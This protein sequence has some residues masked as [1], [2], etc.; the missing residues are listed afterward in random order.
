MMLVKTRIGISKIQGIGIFADEFIPKGTKTWEFTM[1]FDLI[2]G[3]EELEKFPEAAR[4][5]FKK[6]A[7]FSNRLGKYVLEFDDA[8]FTNHSDE[9]NTFFEYPP[10]VIE[11]YEY[12]M[13]DI[14]CGEEIT[15]DYWS[16]DGESEYKLGRTKR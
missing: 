2:V 16:F 6:Y 11:G 1:G 7:Y 12:A 4:E 14:Q 13:R 15:C 3:M 8:R 5:Q 10:E 9:P